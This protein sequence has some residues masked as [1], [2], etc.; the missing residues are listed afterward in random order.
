GRSPDADRVRLNLDV[1][2][3]Q[4]AAGRDVEADHGPAVA[5]VGAASRTLGA[6][7][8]AASGSYPALARSRIHFA[9]ENE[10]V[11]FG[12]VVGQSLEGPAGGGAADGTTVLNHHRDVARP[13]DA[14]LQAQLE[15]VTQRRL[16]P[17]ECV[18]HT[19]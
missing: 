3:D 1:A 14:V 7:L 4:L 16:Q 2:E 13:L 19:A 11:P 18:G 5:H 8:Q 9:L 10:L 6:G 12:R 15:P 17:D